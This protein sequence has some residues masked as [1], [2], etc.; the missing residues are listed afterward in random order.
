MALFDKNRYCFAIEISWLYF[1]YDTLPQKIS[2]PL[3]NA[4][5]R[6]HKVDFNSK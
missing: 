4:T 3:S 2:Y 6:A 5:T 1:A